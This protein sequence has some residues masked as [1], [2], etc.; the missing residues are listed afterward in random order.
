MKHSK[1]I[2][3][4]NNVRFLKCSHEQIPL[5]KFGISA[6]AGFAARMG[7][8]QQWWFNPTLLSTQI[9]ELLTVPNHSS[10]VILCTQQIAKVN[11]CS[12]SVQRREKSSYLVII[13]FKGGQNGS[14]N[15][16]GIFLHLQSISM[17]HR[18]LTVCKARG[19]KYCILSIVEGY[20]KVAYKHLYHISSKENLSHVASPGILTPS[21]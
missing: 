6:D 5:C 9:K 17:L 10:F 19:A 8:K 3:A 12:L 11:L 20:K 2:L 1:E 14:V 16:C 4:S 21:L 15:G 18:V 13:V 7:R